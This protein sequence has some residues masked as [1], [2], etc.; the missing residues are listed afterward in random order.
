[1]ATG[2]RHTGAFYT[3]CEVESC[4]ASK[5]RGLK[6]KSMEV[7]T[8]GTGKKKQNCLVSDLKNKGETI[9]GSAEGNQWGGCGGM[10]KKLGMNC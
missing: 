6:G 3:K 9:G 8:G 5:E 2:M 4:H 10:T 7:D 1:L